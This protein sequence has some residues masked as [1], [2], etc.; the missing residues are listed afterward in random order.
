[1]ETKFA[2]L[3]KKAKTRLASIKVTFF[4]KNSRVCPF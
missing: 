4:Q 2:I 3:E 1:M